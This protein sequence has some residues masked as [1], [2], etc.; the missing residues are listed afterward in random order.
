MIRRVILWLTI[1]GF[2]WLAIRRYHEI[3]KLAEILRTGQ[4]QWVI[5]AVLLQI[6]YYI[7]YALTYQAAFYTV[8]LSWSLR[9]TLPVLFGSLLV[10]VITPSAGM[11]GT[12]L[13]VDDAQKHG[14]SPARAAAGTLLVLVSE[15]G[16]FGIIL[17]TGIAYLLHRGD[18]HAYQIIGA[19]VLTALFTTIAGLLFLSLKRPSVIGRLLAWIEHGVLKL[20]SWVHH[21]Q[22]PQRDWAQKLASEFSAAAA[23]IGE[24]PRRL[25]T[26]LSIALAAHVLDLASLYVLFLAF[27]HAVTLE[28][29]ITGYAMGILFWIVSITPQGIGVVEGVMV[30]VFSSL[31]VPPAK[32]TLTSVSWRGLTFWIP[33][34]IGFFT[35]RKLKSFDPG[36]S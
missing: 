15:L 13:F 24:H 5:A 23:A 32:A 9:R 16:T 28:V 27:R 18:L 14:E 35:L 6:L 21:P 2:M 22:L 7:I 34:V 1:A 12:A 36:E 25:L 29:L 3:A 4:W 11:A 30:L 31:G 10:N 8:G 33:L 26:T 19:L 17:I 20:Q